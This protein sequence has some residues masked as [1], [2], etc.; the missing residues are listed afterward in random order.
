MNET[1]DKILLINGPNLNML[2]FR[3]PEQ[4][5]TFS[6]QDVVDLVKQTT[7][8][9]HFSVTAYQSNHEGDL[10]DQIHDAMRT[11]AGILINAGALTH[12]SYALRDALELT[13]LPVIEIHIS[14]IHQR[15]PFR[16]LSVIEDVCLD[17]I[18]GQGINS[19]KLAAEKLCRHLRGHQNET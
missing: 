15:E 4:Y 3:D 12:T 2:G 18:S 14:D 11:H 16:R 5:G 13:H 10:I 1:T 19:Y 6:L 17:Q 7:E 9:F 8:P